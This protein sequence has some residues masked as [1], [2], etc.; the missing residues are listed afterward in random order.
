MVYVAQ[1]LSAWESRDS[2]WF[3]SI[4]IQRAVIRLIT[5][6]SKRLDVFSRW[7]QLMPNTKNHT[8]LPTSPP[9]TTS[10]RLRSSSDS[11]HQSC[12]LK[13]STGACWV[14]SEE[15]SLK[16]HTEL[17]SPRAAQKPA[18]SDLF[19]SLKTLMNFTPTRINVYLCFPRRIINIRY[20]CGPT[21]LRRTSASGHRCGGRRGSTQRIRLYVTS[22]MKIINMSNLETQNP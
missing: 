12:Y 17:Q 18:S 9:R 11:S 4:Q 15:S 7:S 20:V 5:P 14:W 16:L 22:L 3:N 19:T 1:I 21:T 2:S 8:I 10:I 6:L 13:K